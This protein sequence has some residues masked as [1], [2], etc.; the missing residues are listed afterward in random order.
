MPK[1]IYA[2]TV[3]TIQT[4]YYYLNVIETI[5]N[6]SP[7]QVTQKDIDNK[8]LAQKYVEVIDDALFM[9]VREEYREAIFNHIVKE[10]TYEELE[11]RY[12]LT[13]SSMK[14]WTQRF[15]YGVAKEIG[16]VFY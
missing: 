16:E 14:R 10:V 3:K 6:K 9:Y 8:N 15:I 4:Y 7:I 11:R 13:T 1:P 2:K 5:N 12:N